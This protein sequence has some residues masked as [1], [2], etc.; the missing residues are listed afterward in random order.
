[1]ENPKQKITPIQ[2]VES[3]FDMMPD[4]YTDS[5]WA[6]LSEK[7]AERRVPLHGHLELTPQCNFDCKMCYV[8]LEKCQMNNMKELTLNQWYKIIDDAI[9]AGMVFASIT[10]GECLTVP[11]FD[12]LYLYLKRKGILVFVLTNGFLLP[13]KKELF[14]RHPPAHIQVSV[15]GW[16]DDS[17]YAVTGKRAYKR[18]D[19]SILQLRRSGISISVAVTASK[20]LPSVYKIVKHYYEHNIGTTV[21]K[22]LIPPYEST[23][24]KIEDFN[25]TIEQRVE[26]EREI[27]MAT[28]QKIPTRKKCNIPCAGGKETIRQYG[29]SCAAGRTDFSINWKGEM[30]PCVSLPV[31]TGKPLLEGF[32]HSWSSTVQYA[33]SLVRPIECQECAYHAVCKRCYAFHLSGAKQGHCNPQACEE[34]MT[35][36]QQ[37]IIDFPTEV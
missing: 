2:R 30:M 18:V 20:Y 26:V 35:M 1:M 32:V 10:G 6:K 29:L 22:W 14:V 13:E 5:F 11:F 31:V 25:L 17:Y 37:G 24:R 23:N 3:T 12:E 21:S 7:A 33:D 8:H 4:D 34:V 28:D 36:V 27:L 19:D 15:Y 9:D 16:D